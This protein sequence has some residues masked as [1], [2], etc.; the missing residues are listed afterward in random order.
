MNS[1]VDN[2]TLVIGWGNDLRGDDG[3]GRRVAERVRA[4]CLPNVVVC[5]LHQ[6]GPE[7]A[8]DM[9]GASRVIFVDAS[10]EVEE[11]TVRR[12]DSDILPSDGGLGHAVS[13]ES[14]ACLARTLYEADP[15]VW[16]IHVPA[17]DFEYGHDLSGPVKQHAV[18]AYRL[19]RQ[20]I[21]TPRAE[22]AEERTSD[23][24]FASV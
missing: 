9:A 10:L 6:P 22:G 21:A 23:L 2:T 3:V 4:M 20:L 19:V 8:A 5:S 12:V 17:S 15:E 7:L 11:V 14:L 24:A 18:E 16:A 13:P 1:A